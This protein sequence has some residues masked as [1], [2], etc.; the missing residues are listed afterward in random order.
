[1]RELEKSLD[2]SMSDF[3]DEVKPRLFKKAANDF[4]SDAID[5]AFSSIELTYNIKKLDDFAIRATYSGT[6]Y[7]I[8][9]TLTVVL[10]DKLGKNDINYKLQRREDLETG[11]DD[12]DLTEA[13]LRDILSNVN[14]EYG[15]DYTERGF[16]DS[17]A[18]EDEAFFLDFD[19]AEPGKEL[20]AKRGLN[21]F[22]GKRGHR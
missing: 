4:L 17:E 13:S 19:P 20:Y 5:K 3:E 8:T 9:F 21:A 18:L 7:E 2:G 10:S 12:E 1:M 15:T 14:D 11:S 22:G 16:I 6:P